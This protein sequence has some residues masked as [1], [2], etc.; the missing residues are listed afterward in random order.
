MNTAPEFFPMRKLPIYFTLLYLSFYHPPGPSFFFHLQGSITIFPS[1]IYSISST[2]ACIK[3]QGTMFHPVFFHNHLHTFLMNNIRERGSDSNLQ[4]KT[5]LNSL[6]SSKSKK[7]FGLNSI[8]IKNYANTFFH[9][10]IIS[11]TVQVQN[12]II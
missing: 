9:W 4:V 7:L 12:K 1:F 6:K 8:L 3:Q 10:F 11:A 5:I 2:V